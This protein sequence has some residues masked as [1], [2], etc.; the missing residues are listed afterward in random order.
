MRIITILIGVLW[1]LCAQAKGDLSSYADKICASA[2]LTRGQMVINLGKNLWT[3]QCW[4]AK[5]GEKPIYLYVVR[6]SRISDFCLFDKKLETQEVVR[7]F[8][9]RWEFLADGL[10]S[11]L[12]QFEEAGADRNDVI[13]SEDMMGGHTFGPRHNN[14]VLGVLRA[15]ELR[16]LAKELRSELSQAAEDTRAGPR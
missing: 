12:L 6:H 4:E 13:V 7:Y 10:K 15:S 8:V 2:D 1:S 9:D 14:L 3:Y 5:L 11:G 16:R